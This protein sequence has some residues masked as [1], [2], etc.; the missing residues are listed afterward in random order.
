MIAVEALIEAEDEEVRNLAFG[1]KLMLLH[2][3]VPSCA[4]C[5]Q[6]LYNPKNWT[7]IKRGTVECKREPGEPTPCFVCPKIPSGMP[8]TPETGMKFELSLQNWLAWRHYCECQATGD[9]PK[10]GDGE[11][12]PVVKRNAGVI[13]MVEEQVRRQTQADAA[14]RLLSAVFTK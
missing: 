14:S 10:D 9:F 12:D 5:Q 7:K 8:A 11:L 2:P 1:L 3:E 13:R 4:E 6:W